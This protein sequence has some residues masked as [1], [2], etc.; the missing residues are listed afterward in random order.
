MKI[1]FICRHNVFRSRIAEEYL[2]QISNHE[3]VSAGIF[4]NN[5]I[6]IK[7]QIDVPLQY[8]IDL[9]INKSKPIRLEELY[10][11]D[12]IIIIADDV[13][14]ELFNDNRYSL[15]GKVIKWNIK[16]VETTPR[17]GNNSYILKSD[18]IEEIVLNIM[19]KVKKFNEYI[20]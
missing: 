14:L 8:G 3:V 5:W 18:N 10:E 1:M 16:D 12:Y 15:K 9:S 13:S 20:K 19:S 7:E 11:Q 6:L 4:P 17:N 2:K